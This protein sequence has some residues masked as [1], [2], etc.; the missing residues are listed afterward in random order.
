MAYRA[1]HPV[2]LAEAAWDFEDPRGARITNLD[3][4]QPLGE[5]DSRA[6]IEEFAWAVVGRDHR[7]AV[8][9]FDA[10]SCLVGLVRCEAHS[11]EV[12]YYYDG[13]IRMGAVLLYCLISFVATIGLELQWLGLLTFMSTVPLHEALVRCKLC[14]ETRAAFM[15]LILLS[16][17][18]GGLTVYRF[19]GGPM[20][21]SSTPLP[22]ALAH[23]AD[24]LG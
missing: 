7:A 12:A 3:D 11:Q 23:A 14:S 1:Y 8:S 17:L 9:L 4:F 2:S 19:V 13:T 6:E 20:L 22:G 24:G 16:L 10:D 21:S 18:F 15:G 5:R